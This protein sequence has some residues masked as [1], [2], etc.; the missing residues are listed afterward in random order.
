MRPSRL[1]WP[2][3]S[4]EK[5][6][7]AERTFVRLLRLPEP[8]VEALSMENVVTRKWVNDIGASDGV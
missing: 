2:F 1:L 7:P 3:G 6:L 4:V 8:V 5:L